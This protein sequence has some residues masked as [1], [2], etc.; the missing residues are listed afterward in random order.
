MTAIS[1]I[2]KHVYIAIPALGRS[3][4]DIK[5]SHPSSGDDLYWLDPDRLRTPI[6][7]IPVMSMFLRS[8]Q[9]CNF[10]QKSSTLKIWRKVLTKTR[11]FCDLCKNCDSCEKSLK[12]L[13]LKKRRQQENEANWDE[14]LSSSIKL[15]SSE[16]KGSYV[17]TGRQRQPIRKWNTSVLLNL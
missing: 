8:Y 9:D 10:S 16:I 11:D 14:T 13:K 6:Q 3:C 2:W 17:R 5:T 15:L 4:K 1:G 12:S 7:C